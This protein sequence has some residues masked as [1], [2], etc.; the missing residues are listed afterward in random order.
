MSAFRDAA[1]KPHPGFPVPVRE[2]SRW[3]G[4]NQREEA[5]EAGLARAVTGCVRAARFGCGRAGKHDHREHDGGRGPDRGR[6]LREPGDCSLRQA[7]DAAEPGDIVALGANTYSLTLGSDIEI[8]KS[9]TVEGA[10]VTNTSIDGS[11]NLGSLQ[12]GESTRILRVDYPAQVTIQGLTLTHGIDENDEACS[13]GCDSIDS[14]GGG[15][16]FNNGG[17]VTLD[18]VAF[19]N[20][21]GSATPLGGAISNSGGSLTMN[22]VSF[23]QNIAGS[24]GALFIRSGTVT[25]NAVAFDNDSTTCCNGGALYQLGGTT[26]LT[27]TTVVN[28]SGLDGTAAFWIGGGHMTLDN[29]TFSG[30]GSD[31]AT[32]SRL[33]IPPSRIRSSAAAPSEGRAS[34]PATTTI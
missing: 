18:D 2:H 17:T 22:G 21:S 27:N 34:R 16:L 24:A 25:G 14:N 23:T 4:G 7:V 11:Q 20:N 28:S 12:S 29:D 19:A 6:M 26:T 13:S 10:G 31:I 1:R 30:D 32:D 5:S 3:T 8:A 33:P 15:A 9:I